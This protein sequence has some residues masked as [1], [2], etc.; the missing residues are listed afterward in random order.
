[1]KLFAIIVTYNPDISQLKLTLDSLI[2]QTEKVVVVKNSL[3]KV[4]FINESDDK[5][6]IIQLEKNMGI[7][8]AQNRGID[9]AVSQNADYV[10]LSDQ[11]T[12]Y[13]ADFI[14]K[15]IDCFERHKGEKLGCVVPLFYN[16]NKKQYSE[17]FIAKNKTLAAEL[18]KEYE[19]SHAI[20]SG[21]VCPV[22]VFNAVG[23][24]NERFFI[25]WV[26][27][28]WCWR[29]T[30][31]GYKVICD[32]G[33]V[34]HHNMGDSFKVVLGRKIVVYSDFRNYYFFRNGTWL[35]I[36]SHLFTFKE[37]LV[38]YKFMFLKSVLFFMTKGLSLKNVKLIF[39]AKWEGL[40][41]KL[42]N[43]EIVVTI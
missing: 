6:H 37:W 21:T 20:S 27:Y 31:L 36:H 39:K 22:Q 25:D 24:M 32:T 8:Y 2:S 38:F 14:K 33:N 28:E 1:M 17:I 26:D 41:N 35:L 34:I 10:L 30:K 19:V 15:S 16:E 12:V 5:S 42:S 18:G 40:F 29:A 9:Y 4:D 23:T 7:A 3:E 13:P 43:M 11:D